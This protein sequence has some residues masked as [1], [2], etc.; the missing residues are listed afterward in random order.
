MSTDFHKLAKDAGNRL[1]AYILTYA[2]AA[3]G[4][5]F[6]ALIGKDAND[7]S[8][9]Q[10]ALLLSALVLYVTTVVICLLELHVDARRFFYIASQLGKPD[11]EQSWGAY[12]RLKKGRL[13]LIYVSY[14]TAG[15][16]TAL[17]VLF[18]IARMW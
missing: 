2:S 16:A 8:D 12:N 7:F 6:L 3:T 15:L 11:Q 17:V 10:K 14:V 9:L 4:V 13:F 18:L 5:F 1:R